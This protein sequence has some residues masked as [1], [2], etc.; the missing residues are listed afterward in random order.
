[1]T[2]GQQFSVLHGVLNPL[3]AQFKTTAMVDSTDKQIPFVRLLPGE[4]L[5]YI[6]DNCLNRKDQW[7]CTNAVHYIVY[8]PKYLLPGRMS[9]GQLWAYCVF[10]R[11]SKEFPIVRLEKILINL[12]FL[13]SLLPSRPW[14]LMRR[15]H[16]V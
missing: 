5:L 12:G 9:R 8:Q 4:I 15:G 7:V 6:L 13:C 3:I 2:S 11:D 14:P 1:M 10:S 16:T